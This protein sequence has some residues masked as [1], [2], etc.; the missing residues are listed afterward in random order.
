MTI[1]S[2]LRCRRHLNGD[3][4]HGGLRN[5]GHF[6]HFSD[7][8]FCIQLMQTKWKPRL[9]A[10]GFILRK[11][12]KMG[13]SPCMRCIHS[14]AAKSSLSALTSHIALLR[15]CLAFLIN[16][17]HMLLSFTVYRLHDTQYPNPK[18]FGQKA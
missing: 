5:D 6:T 17:I 16:L 11:R 18:G 1:L 10:I 14:C 15:L 13:Q 8:F 7:Y 12:R 3:N 4:G 9:S 2:P